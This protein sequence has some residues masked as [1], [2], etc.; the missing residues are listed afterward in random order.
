[1]RRG[2]RAVIIANNFTEKLKYAVMLVPMI[3]L[4]KYDVRF[5]FANVASS[6]NA[7]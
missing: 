2:I 1:M 6:V 7:Q 3:T 4:K 5:E